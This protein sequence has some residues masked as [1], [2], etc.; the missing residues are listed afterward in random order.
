MLIELGVMQ[1][2]HE[3]VLEVLGGTCV[4]AVAG[5]HGV[6]RPTVHR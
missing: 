4:T 5:I 6:A 1:Q 3:A 2:G